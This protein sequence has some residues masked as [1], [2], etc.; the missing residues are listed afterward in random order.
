VTE[1]EYEEIVNNSWKETF[2]FCCRRVSAL[3]DA[4]DITLEVF[5][6]LWKHK[7]NVESEKIDRWIKR[8]AGNCVVDHYRSNRP[9]EKP[10]FEELDKASPLNPLNDFCIREDSDKVLDIMKRSL[11]DQQ[12]TVLHLYYGC[13]KKGK[14]L[15]YEM[16]L[17]PGAVQQCK[18]RA[19]ETLRVLTDGLFS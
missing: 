12:Q 8:V 15:A 10:L 3:D 13:G 6:R 19:L 4:E 5:F 16:N 1:S 17:T 18:L 14:Q 2:R 9:P 11:T 7:D